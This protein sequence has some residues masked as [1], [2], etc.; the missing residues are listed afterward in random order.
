M[1]DTAPQFYNSMPTPDAYN[2]LSVEKS[3]KLAAHIQTLA[4]KKG[5]SFID[6][7]LYTQVGD[8]GCHMTERSHAALG[9][10]VADV[11]RHSRQ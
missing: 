1:D 4:E 6:A 5:T 9:Q 3:H 7:A 2:R 10:A 8:D 11:I